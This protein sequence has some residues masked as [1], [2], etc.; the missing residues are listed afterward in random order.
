MFEILIFGL[1]SCFN[2]TTRK[3]DVA[4]LLGEAY[5]VVYDLECIFY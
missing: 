2:E 5:A 1:V 3:G 4:S